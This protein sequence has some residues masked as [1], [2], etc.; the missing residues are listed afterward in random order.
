MEITYESIETNGKNLFENFQNS[1][2]LKVTENQSYAEEAAVAVVDKLV[3]EI[4][5]EVTGDVHRA[6]KLGYS[7]LVFAKIYDHSLDEVD[8]P[9]YPENVDSKTEDI[10]CPKCHKLIHASRFAPHLEKCMQKGRSSSRIASQR[11]A[12]NSKECSYSMGSDEDDDWKAEK[13]RSVKKINGKKKKDSARKQKPYKTDLS[14]NQKDAANISAN[15]KDI[16]QSPSKSGRENYGGKSSK[17]QDPEVWISPNKVASGIGDDKSPV[18]STRCGVKSDHTG[19]YCGRSL[20]C[21][22]HSDAERAVARKLLS[23]ETMDIDVEDVDYS[24]NVLG[25]FSQLNLTPSTPISKKKEK[26]KHGTPKY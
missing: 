18:L 14:K 5:R 12:N 7:N 16:F 3:E 25:S 11:I 24:K 22:L 19:K 8:L 20:R 26:Q 6:I 10:N 9:F 1:F 15:I 2:R 23:A 21:P 13:S 4:L 17:D